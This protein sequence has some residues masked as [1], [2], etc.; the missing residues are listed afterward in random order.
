MITGGAVS[1]DSEEAC[2]LTESA[3]GIEDLRAIVDA[4]AQ[5]AL[6]EPRPRRRTIAA[7]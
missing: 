4:A 2:A 7:G 3:F 5:R 1:L 6:D